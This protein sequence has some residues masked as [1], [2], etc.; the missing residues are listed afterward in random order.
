MSVA[1]SSDVNDELAKTQWDVVVTGLGPVGTTLCSL[2]G[3]YGLRILGVDREK[4]IYTL[5]RAGHVDHTVLRTFEEIGCLDELLAEMIPNR[6]MEL[7]NGNHDVLARIPTIRRTPSNLPPSMHLHQPVLERLLRENAERIEGVTLRNSMRLVSF[8]PTGGL[9]R[10]ALEHE[11]RTFSVTTR[12]LVGCDGASSVTRNVAGLGFRDY[13]FAESWVV[14]DLILKEIPESLRRDTTFVAD[15]KRPYA[16]IEMPGMRYRFEFMVLPGESVA[17]VVKESTV[18][19]LISKWLHPHQVQKVERAI[20]YTFRGAQAE[21]WRRGSVAIAGDAAHLTPPFLGQGLC[22]G[23]RDAANLAWKIAFVLSGRLPESILDTYG[24]ERGPH[25][26]NVITTSIEIARNLCMLDET[27]AQER[28][29]QMLQSGL[30]EEKRIRFKLGELRTGPLIMPSGGMY[31]ARPV[32][33]SKKTDSSLDRKFVILARSETA[34]SS[35]AS[36]NWWRALGSEIQILDALDEAAA[37]LDAWLQRLRGN[38]AV[39]RPDKYVLG[40]E[41]ELDD[42]TRYVQSNLN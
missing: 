36:I 7:L 39:I 11:G 23:V 37:E 14:I 15:P 31:A 32:S 18:L 22:S 4:S 34:L 19:R 27:A 16:M 13:G 5:P 3:K 20:V 21:H 38:V 8:E 6:G 24:I 2:L 25:V 40:C 35:K 41:K 12:F 26:D 9:Q 42:I 33:A 30:P 1:G 29:R 10:V 28:D 17:S